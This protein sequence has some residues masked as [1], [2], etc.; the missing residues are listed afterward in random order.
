M[1]ACASSEC[2]FQSR[3]F[4]TSLKN[5]ADGPKST[6]HFFYRI[7]ENSASKRVQKVLIAIF[8]HANAYCA[9][10]DCHCWCQLINPGSMATSSPL[11]F[12]VFLIKQDLRAKNEQVVTPSNIKVKHP[13]LAMKTNIVHPNKT[14]SAFS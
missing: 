10:S 11:P 8:L 7:L 1:Y 5:R 13:A 6:P 14:S 4:C 2:L 3:H 12:H 9:L